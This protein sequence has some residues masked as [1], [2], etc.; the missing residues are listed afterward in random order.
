L[1]KTQFLKK[2]YDKTLE[3]QQ[4]EKNIFFLHIQD[5]A[6]KLPP[7]FIPDTGTLTED[8]P[9]QLLSAYLFDLLKLVEDEDGE[10]KWA[11][12]EK[13]SYGEEVV[14]SDADKQPLYFNALFY[15][16]HLNISPASA[17]ALRQRVA[18]YRS[19]NKDDLKQKK[20][21][22]VLQQKLKDFV[23]S[24]LNVINA[25]ISKP[26]KTFFMDTADGLKKELSLE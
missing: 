21:K 20:T 12:V 11:L 5:D 23:V 24:Q 15:K 8:A 7:L 22:E 10:E 14:L 6:F 3:G 19:E 2:Q 17:Q 18:D 4:A 25:T 13:N 9:Q 16:A 26:E 1:R